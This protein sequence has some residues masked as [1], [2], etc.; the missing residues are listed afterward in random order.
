VT[1]LIQV[2]VRC[3]PLFGKEIREARNQ[4]V[5]C[6]VRRGEVRIDNP[7]TPGDPPKQF[8]FDGVYDH[9][10]T[11]KEI[12]EGCALPIV[13]AAIEGYNGTIFCYGQTGTGKTHTM[14]GKDEPENERGLIPN[15][16]ETVF[17]DIDALEAANKNFL[18]RASFLEI[19]NENVRDL[20]GKDQSRT[21]DLKEDPDKGVYVKDLTTFVV[22]SV[23]EI[24]K[25]HEVGKKNRSVGATLMN[26]DSSRSHSIFTVTIETSEV[27]E[28]EAEEDAHIRVGKLNMVD[29]AGSERQAKTGSTG[30]RLKEATKINLSLSAL[31]NVISALVDGKSSHI[32]YRDSKLTRLLQDS[33]G[34]NTKTVMIANLGPAD[35]NFDETM[36]TLR[37]AN[38]AKNIKNKPK[39]NEDPKDAMLRE[40]Q[41][42]IA[43]LKTQLGDGGEL[44]GGVPGSRP[45]RRRQEFIEKTVSQVSDARLKRIRDEMRQQMEENMRQN[46]EAE[47]AEKA[48]AKVQR[49]AQ[50]Q[51][52][53]L[54]SEKARTEDERA[55]LEAQF[56]RQQEEMDAKFQDLQREREEQKA[57]EDSLAAMQAKVMRGGTNLLDQEER[58]REEQRRQED[59]LRKIAEQEEDA[60][61]RIQELEDLQTITSDS[62]K[63]IE[64]EIESK[65]KKTK[66]LHEAYERCLVDIKDLERDWTSEREDLLDVIRALT[67]EIKLKNLVLDAY[68]P[69]DEI[70]RLSRHATW[71]DKAETWRI[72]HARIAGNRARERREKEAN[73]AC[74]KNGAPPPNERVV[75]AIAEANGGD[76]EAATKLATNTYAEKVKG[77]YRQ[78]KDSSGGGVAAG[79]R[80]RARPGF[81]RPG[82]A[83]SRSKA[84]VSA[85]KDGTWVL[86]TLRDDVADLDEGP[87]DPTRLPGRISR[88]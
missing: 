52:D 69:P 19:Y 67:R 45:G 87:Q 65:G 7:K 26:A 85:A 49:E 58:L 71:D 76:V 13:R 33:L 16:F 12:F 37:Y 18:V 56:K 38:R 80:R 5:D 74:G 43:R 21:C 60:Q 32:P 35:Y 41:E 46:L 42:E 9:T 72:S 70:D 77:V 82:S 2:V 78:Y 81:A 14:E 8:T 61:R 88:R 1:P 36:S 54:I 24:R 59:E 79:E 30:D 15:T 48:Q 64:E 86:G 50:E 28:G 62:Y 31:G 83:R 34:G 22:K 20:L 25:L 27:N 73:D 39:I 17:G 6:D 11:Q 40:F 53:Q 66:K 57:L 63:T 3:R 51:M 55:E 29:L 84:S 10:S 75:A 44:T 23:A 68:I 47:E 4:I